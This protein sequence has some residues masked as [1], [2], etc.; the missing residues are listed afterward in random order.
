MPFRQPLA[1]STG[2]VGSAPG[3]APRSTHRL[4]E[5]YRAVL[6]G[7]PDAI[8]V[9]EGATGEIVEAN[10][11]AARLLDTT[12]KDIIGRHQSEL[13]PP[14]Q[15]EKYRTLFE[16]HK[17]AAEEGTATM[18]VLNDGSR[19]HVV[20]DSGEKIPVEISASFVDLDDETLFVG[21]F[22]DVRDRLERERALKEAK[23]EVEQANRLISS[24]LSNLN[25]EIRTP[26]TSILGFSKLLLDMLEGEAEK[27]VETIYRSGQR[28][29]DTINSVVELAK[30]ESGVLQIDYHPVRLDRVAQWGMKTLGSKADNSDLSLDVQC[31]DEPVT[32]RSNRSAINRIVKHLVENAIK[33]TPAGGAITIRVRREKTNGIL[34]VQDTGVGMAPSDVPEVFEA[35]KQASEGV[36]RDYS[37]LGV[38]LT[39][40]DKLTQKLGGEI[41]VDTEEGSGSRFTV[42]LPREFS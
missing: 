39:I 38:G 21:I 26:I 18:K 20:A 10:Q 23:E 35:F 41:D 36:D 27:H 28:T 2:S 33:F 3:Q 40:V 32:V 37:G 7:A 29:L 16:H 31:P 25:H 13:H 4:R 9:A 8:F 17:Q 1:S 11:A 42:R 30:L 15:P 34:E 24:L 14:G 6:E 12:V 5:K 22:R 19:I